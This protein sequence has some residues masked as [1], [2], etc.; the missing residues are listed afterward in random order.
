[1]KCFIT[2]KECD[3]IDY[4]VEKEKNLFI[5]SPFGFPFD[6]IYKK[7]GT[8]CR[9][10]IENENTTIEYA[11]RADQALQLGFIMCQRICKKIL[12][13]QYIL[14]DISLPNANVYYELGLSYSFG[15]EII[16]CIIIHSRYND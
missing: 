16:F 1:M 3:Q 9:T 13:S 12:N 11:E 10:L 2:G 7:D 4:S 14:A 8:I 5:I 6:D 15:K